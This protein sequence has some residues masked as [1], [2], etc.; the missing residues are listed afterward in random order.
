M[1]NKVIIFVVSLSAVFL[2]LFFNWEMSGETWGYWF[3]AKIF[4]ETS[5]FVILDR[6]P[7]YVLYLN[8]FL[9]INYP[10]SVIAEYIITTTIAVVILATFYRCYA[11]FWIAIIAAIIWIP[12]LQEAEPPVQKLALAC[13]LIAV[14]IRTKG[15]NYAVIM[16]YTFLFLAY[17]FRQTYIILMLVY[18]AYDVI[19][20]LR[21]KNIRLNF[22]GIN[23]LFFLPLI[24]LL[25]LFLWFKFHQDP[26]SW[27]N[28]W[29]TS[30][31]EWFPG[32]P[33]VLS[34]GGFIQALNIIFIKIKYGTFIG[35]DFYFTNAEFFSSPNGIIEALKSN[36]KQVLQMFIY[37]IG[38]LVPAAMHYSSLPKVGISWVDDLLIY[39]V[40]FGVIYGALMASRDIE[41]KLFVLGSLLLVV[42]TVVSI[43]KWR[44]MIVMVPLFFMAA[45]WYGDKTSAY[46]KNKFKDEIKFVRAGSFLLAAVAIILLYL[47]FI[48]D[49]TERLL[50]NFLIIFVLAFTIIASI[51]LYLSTIYLS[52]SNLEIISIKIREIPTLIFIIILS[53]GQVT[54]WSAIAVNNIKEYK[55]SGGLRVLESRDISMKKS[56]AKIKE[57]T[58][59]CE[60]IM[61]L[62]GS[63]FGAF[64][65]VSKDKIY[66]PWEIPPFGKLTDSDY[67]GLSQDRVDCL[68]ISND[69]S[70]GIGSG[71][72]IQIRYQNY[73]KPYGLELSSMGA[74]THKVEGYGKAIIFKPKK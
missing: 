14:L 15:V 9:W 73:I 53:I 39:I 20:L 30:S 48:S 71:T 16:S 32:D 38:D 44:Y 31:T 21:N 63:F 69:M 8:L 65:D 29:F 64:L 43:P 22:F 27:N 26:T 25:L 49:N 12:F 11:N 1:L 41:V 6:S 24:G 35:H 62:E 67:R 33:K 57:L 5:N 37:N 72:N 70:T 2:S 52:K 40:F 7:L 61:T 68:L 51:I 18:I 3:F 56:Y 46:L 58:K 28:V 36:P 50:R 47:L 23:K 10:Y 17:L 45:S 60:G 55:L 13:S 66:E 59:D 19:R 54:A 42:L 4:S 74:I 34:G